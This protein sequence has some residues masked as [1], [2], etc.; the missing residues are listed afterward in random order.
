M[1]GEGGMR[2]ATLELCLSKMLY[3]NGIGTF[4][5]LVFVRFYSLYRQL[6]TADRHECNT[7]QHQ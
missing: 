3:S 5:H 7:K 2:G 1:L 4:V 6:Y